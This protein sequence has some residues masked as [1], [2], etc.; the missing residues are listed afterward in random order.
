M[1]LRKHSSLK[2]FC[3]K[4]NLSFDMIYNFFYFFYRSG[5]AKSSSIIGIVYPVIVALLIAMI[6]IQTIMYWKLV[7]KRRTRNSIKK[8]STGADA[9]FTEP[10]LL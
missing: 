2:D 8:R 10:S 3:C 9:C 6:L 4:F 7:K 1:T 5:E